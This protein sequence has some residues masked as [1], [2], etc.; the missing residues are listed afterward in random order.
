MNPRVFYLLPTL[1]ASLGMWVLLWVLWPRRRARGGVYLLIFTAAAALWSGL[2]GMLYLELSQASK[3]V[4]TKLQYLG[5]T[6]SPVALFLFILLYTGRAERISRPMLLLA[7]APSLATLVLALTNE[8]HLLVWSR[9]WTDA[10]GPFPM[11]ALVHGP[12]YWVY[13][14][15]CY[16]LVLVAAWLLVSHGIHVNRLYRKQTMLLLAGIAL[17]FLANFLYLSRLS[18]APNLDLTS[19][20]FAGLALAL[21][22]GFLRFRFL[23]LIPLAR[24]AIMQ[25]LDSG[26]LVLD[27][28]GR[29]LDYNPAA[30]RAL[31]GQ[32]ACRTGVLASRLLGDSPPVVEALEGQTEW[33]GE[34]AMPG[35]AGARTY[36]VRLSTVRNRRGEAVG[37]LL[38]LDDVS[39]RKN[40]EIE[41]KHLAATD[42]LTG[43]P[44]RRSF[45]EQA[46]REFGLAQRHGQ[47]LSMLVLDVDH[48]KEVNDR[49]GHQAG[50]QALRDLTQ[51]GLD[52]LRQSDM[53]ARLGGEEFAVLLPRTTLDEA[54]QAAERLRLAVRQRTG[55]TAGAGRALTVSIGAACLR[56]ED[57]GAEDLL[58]RADAAMY[59]AKSQGRDRCLG[60][61]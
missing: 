11:L 22:W 58:R 4:L 5:V 61:D 47:P 3:I 57:Q 9:M 2:E 44:N 52:Q 13:A 46:G 48:F 35:G 56:P 18:P 15:Y 43:L 23:D 27:P 42:A 12:V 16:G 30:Q 24:A 34:C 17:P 55:E 8:R 41:L 37:R 38:V 51:V 54:L 32:G 21:A 45:F 50:D 49:L 6:A 26:V 59:Q 25:E 31:G 60:Q 19:V 53:L 36:E 39:E 40:L 10:S 14:Y 29:V 20:A 28:Q 1:T 33:R 7:Y